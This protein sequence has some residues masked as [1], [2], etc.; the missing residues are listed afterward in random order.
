MVK[1]QNDQ[2]ETEKYTLNLQ[3]ETQSFINLK[4]ERNTPTPAKTFIP[5]TIS[6]YRFYI[7]ENETRRT[8]NT[9]CTT[10]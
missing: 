4:Q 5:R 8:A 2:L 1:Q 10:P 7:V 3:V 9:C 6:L